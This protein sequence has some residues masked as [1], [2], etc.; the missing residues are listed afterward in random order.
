MLELKKTQNQNNGR[1]GYSPEAIVLHITEGNFEGTKSW[2]KNPESKV[3]YHYIVK[4]N[5]KIARFVNEKNT[6]WHAG[7][8]VNPMW[9]NIKKGINPNYYTIGI[10]FEGYAGDTLT[11]K[12]FFLGSL[13][14][15]LVAKRNKIQLNRNT[16]VPHYLITADKICPGAGIDIEK[17]IEV[18]NLPL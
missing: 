9:D 3:S 16:L 7:R 13:L 1:A 2:I 12:Q 5:G 6:A 8:V 15:K 4:K 11:F 14:I 17:I 18:A 10:A